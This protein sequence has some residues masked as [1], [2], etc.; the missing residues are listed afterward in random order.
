MNRALRKALN[1][2]LSIEKEIDFIELKNILIEYNKIYLSKYF[3]LNER[4]L[5]LL[6]KTET[7]A[8][9]FFSNVRT[10][11]VVWL[12]MVIFKFANEILDFKPDE[13]GV[14]FNRSTSA[15][16]HALKMYKVLENDKLFKEFLEKL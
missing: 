8:S 7:S 4:M 1:K 16:K 2:E 15:V 6:D 13:I 14:I 12:R 9:D 11:D 10:R 3:R 5:V